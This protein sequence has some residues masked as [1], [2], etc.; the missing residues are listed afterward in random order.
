M[1]LPIADCRLPIA[2]PSHRA[3]VTIVNRKS[4]IV[5][6]FT[7]VELLVVIAI[8]GVL[9]GFIFSAMGGVK[10]HQYIT[11]TQA[12][13]GQLAAAIDSL[14]HRPRILSA[15]QSGG[16]LTNQLYYELEG[17]YTNGG[18]YVTLDGATTIS[19][20]NVTTAFG[21]GGFVNSGATNANT[22]E[23]ARIARNFIRELRP[24]QTGTFTV[25]GVPVTL[26]VA[27]VGGPDPLYQPMG[28]LGMNPWRYVSPGVNNPNSYDLWVQLTVGGRKYLVCNWSKVVQVNN[29]LP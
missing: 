4:E 15:G 24:N 18:N 27:S 9:A 17:T 21:V 13:M 3:A 10:R 28:V 8:I 12:E 7:L 14:P 2:T 16:T 5:N 29:A 19:I 1:K 6:G 20:A 11:H 22:G 26:L 25:N 23:E